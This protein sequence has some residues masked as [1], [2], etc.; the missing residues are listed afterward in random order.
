MPWYEGLLDDQRDAAGHSGTHARLLAG[1]GTGKTYMLTS[2]IVY[3]VEEL[4]VDPPTIFVLTFTSSGSTR[5]QTTRAEGTGE[6]GT[7][8]RFNPVDGTS[9]LATP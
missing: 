4:S 7:P 2:R 5:T 8:A 3:L 9:F 1:P 6:G